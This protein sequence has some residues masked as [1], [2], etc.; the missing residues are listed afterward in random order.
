LSNEMVNH[1]KHYGGDEEYEC[2]KVLKAWNKPEEYI[3]F[4]KDNTIKYL[5]RLGKKFDDKMLEDARKAEW[6][7]HKL[8]EFLEEQQNENRGEHRT[9]SAKR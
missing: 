2:I 5:C 4:V 9:S 6:Y 1:P 3:G 8:V 7:C